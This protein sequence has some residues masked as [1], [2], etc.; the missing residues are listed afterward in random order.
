[1]INERLLCIRCDYPAAIIT[2]DRFAPGAEMSKA[3]FTTKVNPTYDD[4]PEVRY[5]FPQTSLAQARTTVDDWIV[6]CEPRRS[7]GPM[8][9]RG[10]R[11]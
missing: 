8:S 10:G 6:N 3:V 5:N 7:N 4:L 2:V 11:Q 1:M 9:S